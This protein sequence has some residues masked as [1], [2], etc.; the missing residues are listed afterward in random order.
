[1]LE[2]IKEKQFA[3]H[4]CKTVRSRSLHS[5]FKRPD[6][7]QSQG[8]SDTTS[9]I[10]LPRPAN[11]LIR[12]VAVRRRTW[13]HCTA[14]TL[15]CSGSSVIGETFGQNVRTSPLIRS[16]KQRLSPNRILSSAPSGTVPPHSTESRSRGYA[17]SNGSCGPVQSDIV[18]TDFNA[19]MRRVKPRQLFVSTASINEEVWLGIVL[20]YLTLM[21]NIG[22][23][24]R[25]YMRTDSHCGKLASML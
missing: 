9:V 23:Y 3:S 1:M 18:G 10:V 15:A 21:S 20:K 11:L 22:G 25:G 19:L 6:V 16:Y 7:L 2:E 17:C 8:D 13:G 14:G 12:L 24:S 5:A 4:F